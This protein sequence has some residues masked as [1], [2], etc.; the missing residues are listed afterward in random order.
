M[1]VLTAACLNP[2]EHYRL[3]IGQLQKGDPADFIVV[4][5]LKDFNVK[6][7][8]IR[9]ECVAS[10]GKSF[11]ERS[12]IKLL[13]YFNCSPKRE[14]DFRIK[15]TGSRINVIKAIPG[16]LITEKL[17]REASVVEGNYVSDASRDILKLVVVNRYNN[18]APSI[19]FVNGIGLKE[20]AIASSVAH[21]SHN[22]IAAGVDDDS[23]C[24]A[25]NAIIESKGGIS[26]VQKDEISLL[27]LPIGGLMSDQDG[28]QVALKYA[29]IKEKSHA[30][31][32]SLPDP[33]MAL[34][35]LALLVIPSLKLS[36]K[37]LFDA[38]AFK[39]IPLSAD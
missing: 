12:P 37:G 39:F 20:G 11:I 22:I 19:A 16:E 17:V 26:L 21:D 38:D 2:N 10:Q 30:I 25:V 6:S 33:F 27:P 18:I 7:T 35:F 15:S 32:S 3:G 34:S 5:N 1:D 29:D 8:Y 28:Y 36:D 31:G 24:R 13:N 14:E 9:G 23:I 4:D